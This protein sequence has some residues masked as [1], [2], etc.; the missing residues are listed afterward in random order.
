MPAIVSPRDL[1]TR[2]Y[3]NRESEGQFAVF[4]ED[5][6]SRELD[7]YL[8]RIS[9][10]WRK[11]QKHIQR[12][13]SSKIPTNITPARSQ[14]CKLILTGAYLS[15]IILLLSPTIII[16]IPTWNA[17]CGGGD[18]GAFMTRAYVPPPKHT[19]AIRENC[20]SCPRGYCRIL[21]IMRGA[22]V[23]LG[24]VHAIA[25]EKKES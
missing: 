11:P 24:S 14:L 15:F 16:A 1:Q 17:T 5:I 18:I 12:R 23:S 20:G 8:R 10:A 19:C 7:E 6:E 3:C 21:L 9:L 13:T 22:R 25:S 4:N 2:T